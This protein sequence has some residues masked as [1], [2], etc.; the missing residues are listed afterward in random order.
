MTK[1]ITR[2]YIAAS[3]VKTK[4]DHYDEKF[5]TFAEV[6]EI[7][8][9]LQAEFN[10]RDIDVCITDN[11][12]SDFFLVYG[13]LYIKKEEI[14]LQELEDHYKAYCPIE[15]LAVIWD[16]AFIFENLQILRLSKEERMQGNQTL[17]RKQ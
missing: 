1:F 14:T 13:G 2:D 9:K 7:S 6:N 3:I 4:N 12:I 16:D 5:A 8:I 10:Q 11:R 15:A 17:T